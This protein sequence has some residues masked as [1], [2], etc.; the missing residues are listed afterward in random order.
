MFLEFLRVNTARDVGRDRKQRDIAQQIDVGPPLRGPLWFVHVYGFLPGGDH[1]GQLDPE[2]S[3]LTRV[4]QDLF[5]PG[6]RRGQFGIARRRDG[7]GNEFK[8]KRSAQ[9]ESRIGYFGTQIAIEQVNML[10]EFHG[11][12]HT[13]SVGLFE[14]AD[15]REQPSQAGHADPPRPR[16]CRTGCG[17]RRTVLRYGHDTALETHFPDCATVRTDRLEFLFRTSKNRNCPPPQTKRQAGAHVLK[18]RYS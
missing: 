5:G 7:L 1:A 9:L 10:I 4:V 13:I 14:A 16:Q 8:T 11:D 15:A 3:R 18:L 17:D 12:R 6:Y 2:V